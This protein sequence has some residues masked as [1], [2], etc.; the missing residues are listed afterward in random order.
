MRTMVRRL[1]VTAVAAALAAGAAVAPAAP[2]AAIPKGVHGFQTAK[3]GLG[4]VH[5]WGTFR[6][7]TYGGRKTAQV[8]ANIK[9]TNG[10]DGLQAAL[11]VDFRDAKGASDPWTLWNPKNVQGRTVQVSVQSY[12]LHEL[13]IRECRG[14]QYR[15]EWDGKKKFHIKKCG[16]WRIYYRG[17]KI[18]GK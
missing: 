3:S 4:G 2:A 1:T 6:R 12:Y 10:K 18:I 7:G 14:W 11:Q 16:G 9:D 15:D 17:N 5:G 13:R 8:Y